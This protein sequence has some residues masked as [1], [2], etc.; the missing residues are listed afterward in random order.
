M[1]G[2]HVDLVA[3]GNSLDRLTPHQQEVTRTLAGAFD[4]AGEE[5]Y[6]VGGIVRDAS[7]RARDVR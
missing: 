2:R 1:R 6:L 7:A 5:L 4:A 3:S